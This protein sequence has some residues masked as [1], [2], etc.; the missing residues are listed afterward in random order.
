MKLTGKQRENLAKIF[1]DIGKLFIAIVVLGQWVSPAGFNKEK[2]LI[3][4]LA[5]LFLFWISLIIDT[6][7]K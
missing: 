3:G 1:A 5:A 6:G 7:G 4:I 2:L